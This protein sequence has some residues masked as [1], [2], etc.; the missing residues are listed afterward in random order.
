MNHSNSFN[1]NSH[2]TNSHTT[3]INNPNNKSN[4]H[5]YDKV[6]IP[7]PPN[8]N[9]SNSSNNA[10]TANIISNNNA[11]NILKNQL[12]NVKSTSSTTSS[13]SSTSSSLYSSSSSSTASKSNNIPNNCNSNNNSNNNKEEII[14]LKKLPNN[15]KNCS[16]NDLIAIISRMLTSLIDIND[17][18][19][20][21]NNNSL[22]TNNNSANDM[23]NLNHENLTRF[24]SRTPPQISVQSYLSRLSQYSSLEN[25]VLLTSIYYIDLLC[26]CYPI[27]TL[28]SLTVHRF[29]LTATTVAS[30]ALCDSF[31]SNSHYAKVG[32]VNLIELNLLEVEF[33]NKVNWRVVPRDFSIDSKQRKNSTGT[34]NFDYLKTVKLGVGSAAEVL[35]LYYKRMV[36]L[37]GINMGNNVNNVNNVNNSSNSNTGNGKRKFTIGLNDDI[38]YCINKDDNGDFDDLKVDQLQM[39]QNTKQHQHQHQHQQQQQQQID[40]SHKLNSQQHNTNKNTQLHTYAQSQV[41]RPSINYLYSSPSSSSL[42][43]YESMTN[44]NINNNNNNNNDKIDKDNELQRQNSNTSN[45]NTINTNTNDINLINDN[46]KNDNVDTLRSNKKRSADLE[47]YEILRNSPKSPYLPKQSKKT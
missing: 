5:I 33:L 19:S 15:F 10:N 3:N 29:L 39:N 11:N 41:H 30:K 37:V 12:T 35:E 26:S 18:S 25:A 2:T 14:N 27:F 21:N 31:C 1:A 13:S 44:S 20:N 7:P 36:N 6:I 43:S 47:S 9:T 32:G 17:N 46:E 28:N 45:H 40:Q 23:S 22:N 42:S 4:Y 38:N 34:L 24:H 16:K 8:N